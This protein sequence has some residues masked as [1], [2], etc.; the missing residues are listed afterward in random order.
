MSIPAVDQYI[1]STTTHFSVI[2]DAQE[3]PA[4]AQRRFGL[5]TYVDWT[6]NGASISAE[7]AGLAVQSAFCSIETP[8]V[9]EVQGLGGLRAGEPERYFDCRKVE[10]MIYWVGDSS[11]L[12]RIDSLRPD[13]S[14]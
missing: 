11:I 10:Q 2:A 12:R 8:A 9:V 4:A 7:E 1:R 14:V 3:V 6:K 5:K 13:R